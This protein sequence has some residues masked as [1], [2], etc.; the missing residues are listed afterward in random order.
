MKYNVL[1]EPLT[2]K[3]HWQKQN[4]TINAEGL[5]KL[6]HF[7]PAL[8]KYYVDSAKQKQYLKM[9]LMQ[10]SL[11]GMKIANNLYKDGKPLMICRLGYLAI[12]V[13]SIL[14]IMQVSF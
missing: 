13:K 6:W 9:Q 5:K 14:Q 11:N 8:R 12:F 10:K 4:F 7:K 1:L 2:N 3:I